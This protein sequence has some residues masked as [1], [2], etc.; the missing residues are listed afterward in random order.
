MHLEL[1]S[2]T[3]PTPGRCELS[4]QLEEA[5]AAE[6]DDLGVVAERVKVR[7][8]SSVDLAGKAKD[9]ML[10]R[11]WSSGE[12]YPEAFPYRSRA[13]LALQRVDGHDVLIFMMYTQEYG[14]E[15]PEPAY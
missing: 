11:Q 1:I 4:T 15:C 2:P 13:I 8:V 5:V 9:V 12:A 14:S 6:L 7:V 3:S 10:Q